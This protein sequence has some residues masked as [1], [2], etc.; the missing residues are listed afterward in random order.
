[1]SD[2]VSEKRKS[3]RHRELQSMINE[4]RIEDIIKQVT[5]KG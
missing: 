4:V 3:V 5:Q 1:M 2:L